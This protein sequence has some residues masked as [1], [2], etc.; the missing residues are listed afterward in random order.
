MVNTLERVYSFDDLV[1]IIK[2]RDD[3]YFEGYL[4]NKRDEI[5]RDL[6]KYPES[7]KNKMLYRS[8]AY[9]VVEKKYI[10]PNEIPDNLMV[11]KLP[12]K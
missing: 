5:N 7:I 10:D 12:P 9:Y 6:Y 11:M 3:I 4:N 8:V 2:L 1:K